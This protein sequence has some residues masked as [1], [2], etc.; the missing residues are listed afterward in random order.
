VT[1]THELRARLD[2]SR[3]ALLKAIQGLTDREFAADLEP[4]VTVVAALGS[5]ATSERDAVARGRSAVG[6]PPRPRP[7]AA[8]AALTRAV[9]PQVIHDLAGARHETVAFLDRLSADRL[10]A[11]VN[12]ES[13][14]SILAGI[15]ERETATASRIEALPRAGGNP[16]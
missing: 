8:G 2:A 14:E 1:T 4:G 9:P 3:S 10:Q 16:V 5:L 12:G 15:E 6:M 13:V 11:T 7:A